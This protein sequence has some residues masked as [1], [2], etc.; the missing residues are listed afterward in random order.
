[1]SIIADK[2]RKNSEVKKRG[3]PF[4]KGN[5]NAWK[6]GQSG[7]PA[8]R[9]KSITLS[10]AY[11]LQ[12]AQPVP[13]DPEGRTY[14][15]VIARLVCNE[16]VNGNVAAAREIADRTEG[17]PKQAID[18]DMNVRDWREMARTHG[19]SEQ[20]VFNEAR[21]LITES[22]SDSSDGESD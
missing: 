20:D 11:R 5:A 10:E 13:K 12:L 4:E 2:Q 1:M 6:R 7:N 22:T 15:E 17:K 19:I 9:P 16:A 18:V 21:Q 3:K 14:A 8:G